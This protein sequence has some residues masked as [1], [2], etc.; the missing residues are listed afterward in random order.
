M[1]RLF[2][3]LLVLL[4]VT[5]CS[6]KA[7]LIPNADVEQPLVADNFAVGAVHDESGF[8]FENPKEAFNLED[9]MANA[10]QQA[11]Q[12][13]NMC[14]TCSEY[15]LNT[16]ILEY[17]PG[18]AFARWIV[19]GAGATKLKTETT[20]ASQD[21]TVFATIPVERVIAAGGGYTIG[22]WKYV[23]EDVSKAIVELLEKNVSKKTASK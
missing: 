20:L 2:L 13:K 16:K 22:A 21:G 10:L 12:K 7:Q 19:P 15:V 17:S 3:A 6:T 23:F 14:D 1:K 18:N 8:V 5:G 9:A 11:L 4:M